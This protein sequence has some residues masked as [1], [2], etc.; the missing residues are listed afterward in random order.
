MEEP[1]VCIIG[2]GACGIIAAKILHERGIPF[3]CCEKGSG[4]GGLWRFNNDNQLS[5]AYKSLHINSSRQLMAFSDFPMPVS[6]PDF[7]HHTHILEY[8]ENYVDHFGFRNRIQFRT[9]VRS[10]EPCTEGYAVTTE[11]DGLVNTRRY[12]HVIVANGHHW[13]P[14]TP[15]FPGRFAGES[16]HSFYYKTPEGLENKRVLIVGLGNSGCDIASEVS[17][18]AQKTFLSTR[19]GAHIIPKYLFGK[20]LDKFSRPFM[21]NVLPFW[22]FQRI[23][24][25]ALKV[26]RG[27]LFRFGLPEPTHRVLEE[28]PTVAADLL[29][30]IGHG[31][32]T[33]HPNV[34]QLAG[35]QVTFTDG[36]SEAVDVII[37]ATGYDIKFPFLEESLLNPENNEVPLFKHV[38]HPAR[39]GLYFV[40]LVQ[41][42]GPLNPLSEAQCEWIADLISSRGI[43]PCQAEMQK[44]ITRNRE[45]MRK[46]YANS[47]RHTI[48]VDFYP[49][50][51]ELK[52]IRKRCQRLGKQ[53]GRRPVLLPLRPKQT[54]SQSRH[55][56]TKQRR[57]A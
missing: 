23:F 6:Y 4:I 21:W 26:Q 33:I 53:V 38:V 16:F 50:L 9:T 47:V 15:V 11:R 46:R 56:Q 8:Y 24:A 39:R 29:N 44:A 41:P 28:H 2:A 43:L 48:Q 32:I 27:R 55:Q 30:L 14:R 1:R 37:Y 34:H 52:K 57:I 31:K 10:V 7:P 19:R 22:L 49:Y 13:A 45:K 18:I 40:G 42:W 51:R 25:A 3:D 35:D 20:P 36:S 54:E 5:A 12:E 17:R